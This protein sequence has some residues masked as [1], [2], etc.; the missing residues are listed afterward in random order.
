MDC[1]DEAKLFDSLPKLYTNKIFL[2]IYSTPH[3]L[4]L[5]NMQ[6][7]SANLKTVYPY[8]YKLIPNDN[9]DYAIYHLEQTLDDSF[10][11][12]VIHNFKLEV[13]FSIIL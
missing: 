7:T 4:S 6:S 11:S 12:N 13:F 5:L 3:C 8:L 10:I 9:S 2:S 1:G